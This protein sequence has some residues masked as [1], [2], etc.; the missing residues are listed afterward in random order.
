M[1]KQNDTSVLW[2]DVQ[3]RKAAKKK[4]QNQVAGIIL[5]ALTAWFIYAMINSSR[6]RSTP[7]RSAPVATRRPTLTPTPI[8]EMVTYAIPKKGSFDV[9]MTNA[10][11]GTEQHTVKGK[12]EET[13]PAPHGAFVYL[14]AQADKYGGTTVQIWLNGELVRES[15][16]TGEYCIA[17]ASGR[18]P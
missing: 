9:T 2:E 13:F 1:T 17:S 14:S 16:C 5:M 4:R 10:Q 15:D 3:N 11:G 7:K 18:V 8:F 6:P 12:W